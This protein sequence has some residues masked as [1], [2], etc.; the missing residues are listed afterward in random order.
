M[1]ADDVYVDTR[2]LLL[3]WDS[4]HQC[5]FAEW[6]A[7]ATSSEFQ[8]ALTMALAVGRGK[9]PFHFV[10]DARKLE[11][12]TDEDQRWLRYTFAPL[13]IEAGLT[14]LAVVTARHGLGRMAIE[15]MFRN[16][17]DNAA[18]LQSRIFE[19]IADALKWVAEP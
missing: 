12:V 11:L 10:N 9:H 13:A 4:A 15:D 7:F 19:S 8:G 1:A 3:R 17:S 14:K 16:R 6:K 5:L 2:W 18:Q